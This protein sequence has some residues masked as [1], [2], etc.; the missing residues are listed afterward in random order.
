[1]KKVFKW[2]GIVLSGLLGVIVIMMVVLYFKGK[3]MFTR[4]YNIPD[5][6]IPIPTDAASI[7]RGK[8]FTQAI[9]AGCHGADLSG[10]NMLNAPFMIVDSA[11]LTPSKYG[12]GSEFTNADFVRA[13]R[14]G[15]DNKGRALVI[16]PAQEF[17]HFSD[18]DLGDII[19]YIRSVPA[20]DKQHNDPQM[21]F[22]GYIMTGAGAFGKDI[23]PANEIAQ[24][25]RPSIPAIDVT[26]AYGQ[27]LVNV[28]GCQGCHGAQLAG[29]KNAKPGSMA[30]PNLTPGGDLKG[31]SVDQFVNTLHNGVTPTGHKLNPDEMPWKTIGT[32]TNDELTA[33]FMYLQTLPPMATVKP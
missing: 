28:S 19:A 15:V 18:Q 13:I 32:Y 24:T 11:N 31:W 1:M 22:I 20:V 16:M 17:W 9:C 21:N 8:H 30:A 2:I 4:T 3:A 23:V 5:E 27:Y 33:I 7:A 29:G 14:H 25:E 6:N 26:A 12:A 10:M